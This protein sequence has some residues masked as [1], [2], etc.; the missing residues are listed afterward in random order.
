[1]RKDAARIALDLVN[2]DS[3]SHGSGEGEAAK[4]IDEY[5]EGLGIASKVT[6]FEKGRFNVTAR[7]G[8]GE[9]LMFN[10]HMD[11]VPVGDR[12]QWRYPPEGKII[13]G[14]LYGR[15]S[16][17][18]KGG[19]ASILAALEDAN[20]AAGR[21][22]SIL[23]TFVADEEVNFKGSTWLLEN[24]K[25]LFSGVKYG[26]IAEPTDMKVQVA[27]KG[28]FAFHI[29]VKGVGAHASTPWNGR[30]AILDCIKAIGAL[31]KISRRRR[32][33]RMLGSGTMNIGKIEGGT[34]TNV[35]PDS[36]RVGVDMRLVP[37]ESSAKMLK[38][39]K[40]ALAPL[41][42]DYSIEV[43]LNKEPYKL[44]SNSY[45]LGLVQK[46]SKAEISVGAGYTEAE[47]YYQKARIES[48]VFGPGEKRI[49]H[50]PNEHVSVSNIYKA[51][52]IFAAVMNKWRSS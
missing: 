12:K 51:A 29:T 34:A 23:L 36:C 47:L 2:I 17:D 33:D 40:G 14:K 19:I 4:Y 3:D 25:S 9:G 31:E 46:T 45:I 18:M 5:L 1:M 35:V 13:N 48:V 26:I 50:K 27:Q 20:A 10:G 30:N 39:I 32:K 22:R 38:Q 43:R 24:R 7:I 44:G 11:T 49:I 37:G 16:S 52:R 15:G 28:I 21:K 42:I 41:S 6:E 8:D